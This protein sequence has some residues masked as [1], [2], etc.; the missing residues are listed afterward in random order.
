MVSLEIHGRE[1][2]EEKKSCNWVL[3]ILLPIPATSSLTN[4]ICKKSK[5]CGNK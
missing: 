3:L 4:P 2:A 1:K 5:Y